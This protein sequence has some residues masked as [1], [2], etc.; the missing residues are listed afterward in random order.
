MRASAL[1]VSPWR[2]RRYR[3]FVIYHS[4]TET[5]ERRRTS[6]AVRHP[7]QSGRGEEDEIIIASTIIHRSASLARGFFIL[8][9]YFFSVKPSFTKPMHQPSPSSRTA[10]KGRRP[11]ALSAKP[12]VLAV[13]LGEGEGP[14][15]Q[16][17]LRDLDGHPAFEG[18]EAVQSHTEVSVSVL[19]VN[20]LLLAD[21][22]AGFPQVAF[23]TTEGDVALTG[24]G[25][26]GDEG[27][28][29]GGVGHKGCFDKRRIPEAG[30]PSNLFSSFFGRGRRWAIWCIGPV[31]AGVVGLSAGLAC[32]VPM[33]VPNGHAE[34]PLRGP[35]RAVAGLAASG[36]TWPKPTRASG[37]SRL[38]GPW[39]GSR[40]GRRWPW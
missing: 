7:R 12:Q 31:P 20:I 9:N 32:P 15:V 26:D 2:S 6:E 35:W 25:V 10:G 19:L 21:G 24:E 16:P 34:A 8:V 27:D 13:A 1:A 33:P 37:W 18:G 28:G 40:G 14:E 3:R 38:R 30:S 17:I 23:E 36:L 4:M 39:R 29:R 22:L 5:S 11:E